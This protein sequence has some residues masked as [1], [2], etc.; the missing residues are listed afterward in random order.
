MKNKTKQ[1]QQQKNAIKQKRWRLI[2][3]SPRHVC[4]SVMSGP[5][6]P[7]YRTTSQHP[8]LPHSAALPA[9]CCLQASTAGINLTALR[10]RV[11]I[12]ARLIPH[13]SFSLSVFFFSPPQPFRRHGPFDRGGVQGVQEGVDGMGL[14]G[15][16]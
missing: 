7:A 11:Q 8:P 9:L 12:P 6:P 1:K 4:R 14:L 5:E 13:L 15:P 3:E 2:F 10:L 16:L